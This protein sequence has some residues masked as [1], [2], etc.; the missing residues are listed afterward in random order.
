VQAI[1]TLRSGKQMDNQVVEPEAGE[2]GDNKQKGDA[3]PSTVT[4][5]VID[6]PRLFVPNARYPE[7]LQAPK[8]RGK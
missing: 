2:K 7:R 4:P 5:I 1:V 6:P 8:K 3:K